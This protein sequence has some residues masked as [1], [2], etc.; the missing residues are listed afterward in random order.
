M[1]GQNRSSA[2]DSSVRRDIMSIET[3]NIPA[4][5]G[6]VARASRRGALRPT[7]A[8]V[9]ADAIAPGRITL[10]VCHAVKPCSCCRKIGRMNTDP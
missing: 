7:T 8:I 5:T 9:T 10:P 6:I 3:K 2:P 1:S 4:P